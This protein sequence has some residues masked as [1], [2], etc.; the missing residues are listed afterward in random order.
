MVVRIGVS[1]QEALGG[2]SLVSM[3]E[4]GKSGDR[5]RSAGADPEADYPDGSDH[6]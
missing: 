4:S 2:Q 6:E 5:L 1:R 3:D